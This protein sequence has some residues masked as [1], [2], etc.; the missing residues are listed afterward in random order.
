MRALI[1]IA[2]IAAMIALLLLIPIKCRVY[3][4]Y[5]DE[6]ETS[7]ELFYGFIR[8]RLPEPK[9]KPEKDKKKEEK[10]DKPE[11]EEKPKK[12]PDPNKLISLAWDN[13]D[14]IKRLIYAVL[15]YIFKHLIK[16]NRLKI[17]L[18]I[19]VDDAMQTALIFGAAS[20]FIFNVVGVMDKTMRLARHS[21]DLKPAFNDPHI[22][23][24]DEA[25]ISTSIYHIIAVAVIA[26]R[27]AVPLYMKFRKEI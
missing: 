8:I 22:F 24:E 12:K 18:V 19:G 21:T 26:L 17:K 9:E 14:G 25:V 16:I 15:G 5:D 6:A 20:A 27:Y 7:F 1:I 10:E 4:R 3:F 13:R 23:T 2:V 11:K